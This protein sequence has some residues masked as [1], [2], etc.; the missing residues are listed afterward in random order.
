MSFI[1]LTRLHLRSKRYFPSFFWHSWKS[2]QQAKGS[3]GFLEGRLARDGDGG[4]WTVT[5]WE[6]EEAMR[7]YRIT[8]AHMRARPKLLNWCD[9]ASIAHW[10][11]RE[12]SFPTVK[13]CRH[14]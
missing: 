5:A 4:L 11:R 13:A 14:G 9:E 10:D 8:G 12:T 2:I 3:P 7:A 6:S 1:S